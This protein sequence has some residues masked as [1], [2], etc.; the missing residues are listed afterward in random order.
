MYK[1]R[2]FWEVLE[3]IRAFYGNRDGYSYIGIVFRE[4]HSEKKKIHMI[5]FKNY[6]K[7]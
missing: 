1:K 5:A 3:Q 2:E 4:L 7:F 6:T